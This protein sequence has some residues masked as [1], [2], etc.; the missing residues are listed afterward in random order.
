MPGSLDSY[1][2][3]MILLYLETVFLIKSQ[4]YCTYNAAKTICM[5]YEQQH[6]LKLPSAAVVSNLLNSK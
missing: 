5:G 4:E 6:R 2:S 3:Q 1:V